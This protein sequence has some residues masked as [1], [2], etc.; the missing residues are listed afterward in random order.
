MFHRFRWAACQLDTLAG[1]VT[2][3][4]V[5]RALK[6]LPKTLDETYARILCAIDEGE[7]GEEALKILTWLICAERPLTATEVLQVTGIVT[8][9]PPRF[10]GDEVL[11]D[12]SD[13]LRI[14]SSLVSITTVTRGSDEVS[15][16]DTTDG[17]SFYSKTNAES[18]V[19]YV[20]LAHFSVKEYL[21]SSR[22]CIPRY[23][24]TGQEPHDMLAKC[25]L[26]YLLRFR[27]DEWRN[28]DC[29]SVFPLA[30][31]AA[32]HWT[33][34]AR[35]SSMLSKHQQHLSVEMFTRNTTAFVAWMR[36]FDINEPWVS[37]P[38]I[39][40]AMNEV[41]TALYV[42]SQE[43]LANSVSVILIAGAAVNTKGGYYGT[44]L[45]TAAV[46]G[47]K[48]VVQ[49]LVKA[50]AD[51]NAQGGMH[52]TA[53][54]AAVVR[55][56]K[57]VVQMLVKAGA[58]VNAQG[59]MYNTALQAAVVR[60]HKE[61]VQV[62][63]K[64]GADVNAE[65]GEYGTALQAAV[66]GGDNE[67]VQMLVETG[68][69]VNVEGRVYTT[70]LQAAAVKGHKEVVQMLVKAGADV[71]AQGGMYGTAL[72]A[73]AVRGHNEVVQVLVKAGADVNAQG[74]MHGTALQAAAVRGHKEVVQ[75]LVKAGADVNAQGG[76]YGT[77]LQAAAARG[78]NEVVQVLVKA[79]EQTVSTRSV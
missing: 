15:D 52:G 3:G 57:E 37:A 71:N 2:R 61:V 36:F 18:D 70:A 43:G 59:G 50:G 45:Q 16:D 64:A 9:D 32:R 8:E 78:H 51:V 66:E 35:A 26:V 31:Y 4:K 49:V 65:G 58:D 44:A 74:G 39:R 34:H 55:G 7:H 29:E 76:M 11:E 20:R 24:L 25:C 60:G 13:I 75:M 54:Q 33:R 62:L 48:E 30:R 53:L 17:E 1:C 40:R 27:G 72:Y 68:A 79:G 22:P 56:H 28:P 67:V 63:V 42:A 47:H 14:C 38:D 10:D 69:D 6:E 12:S 19:T 5:R 41:P 77:A 21:D 73:V 46:G 23:R